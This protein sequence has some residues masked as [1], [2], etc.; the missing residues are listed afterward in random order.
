MFALGAAL[1]LGAA[2]DVRTNSGAQGSM[3]D[4]SGATFDGKLTQP[5]FQRIMQAPLSTRYQGVRHITQHWKVGD[6]R[7]DVDFRERVSADGDG[8]FAVDLIDVLEP[9]MSPAEANVFQVL[10]DARAGF[11][12]RY[13]DFMIQDLPTFVRNYQVTNAASYAMVLGQQCYDLSVRRKNDAQVVYH[14]YVDMGTGLVLR[15]IEK[16]REGFVLGTLEYESLDFAPDLGSVA[17]HQPISDEQPISSPPPGAI[18]PGAGDSMAAPRSTPDGFVLLSSVSLTNSS[19]GYPAQFVRYTYTDGLELAFL[20]Y[21]GATAPDL[22]DSVVLPPSVGPWQVV[23]GNI[24][25]QHLTGLGRMSQGDL[26]D[27][28]T[29]A[30]Y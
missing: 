9:Q 8:K 17:W 10:A 28:V 3:Q 20:I 22:D 16:T 11:S 15:C 21:G 29:S 14:V 18:Q 12:Y 7:Y 24:R 27:L 25:G 23:L 6:D 5:L 19:L 1:L 13:R 30:L 26:L 4:G 2:C